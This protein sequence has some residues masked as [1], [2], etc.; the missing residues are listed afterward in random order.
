M[1][2]LPQL[3]HHAH[4][5]AFNLLDDTFS[6]LLLRRQRPGQQ[7]IE[8]LLVLRPALGQDSLPIHGIVRV[9]LLVWDKMVN[10]VN[11]KGCLQLAC[12]TMVKLAEFYMSHFCHIPA[13]PFLNPKV[14]GRFLPTRNS[15]GHCSGEVAALLVVKQTNKRAASRPEPELQRILLSPNKDTWN[16]IRL[17]SNGRVFS[18]VSSFTT[19]LMSPHILFT[20]YQGSNYPNPFRF[21]ILMRF[22]T[23]QFLS[24]IHS[25]CVLR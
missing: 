9:V 17:I 8:I 1:V 16:H 20:I 2:C 4:Q 22:S 11:E 18:S 10:R 14:W 3:F 7:L 5:G 12:S 24:K 25:L 19:M 13:F 6:R 21:K 23:S 15:S